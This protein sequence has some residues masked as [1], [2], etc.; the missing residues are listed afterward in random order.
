MKK[1]QLDQVKPYEAPG[2]FKMV[3]LKLHGKEETGLEKFWI[4]LSHFLPG[5]G[6][7]EY[8]YEDSPTEKVYFVL[9]SEITIK[10]K[11]EEITLGPWESVYLALHEGRRIINKANKPASMLVAISSQGNF[12]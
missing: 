12:S 3:A 8:A 9:N 2:H 4:G 7:A 6:A 10:T 5:G 11:K 1:I